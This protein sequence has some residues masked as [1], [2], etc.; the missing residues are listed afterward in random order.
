M[1]SEIDQLLSP[2]LIDGFEWQRAYVQAI[3]VVPITLFFGL[4]F[5]LWGN[6]GTR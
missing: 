1:L 4:I 6:H 3:L 2:L 5:I